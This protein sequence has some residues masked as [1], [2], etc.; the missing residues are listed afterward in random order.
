M[1]NLGGFRPVSIPVTGLMNNRSM[2]DELKPNQFRLLKNVSSVS[3]GTICRMPGWRA[4][5]E[6]DDSGN[7]VVGDNSDLHDQM[8]ELVVEDTEYTDGYTTYCDAPTFSRPYCATSFQTNKGREAVTL[9]HEFVSGS[10]VR[11][12]I[13]GTQSRVYALS[14]KSNSWRIIADGLGGTPSCGCSNRR[15]HIAQMGSTVV[16][17]NNHDQVLYWKFDQTETGCDYQSAIPIP[18]LQ[19]LEIDK[20]SVVVEYKGFIFLINVEASGTRYVSK[21]V[22]SDIGAPLSW[23]PASGSL[24]GDSDIG[25]PS[26][27]VIEAKVLGDYLWIFKERSI[28]RCTLVDPDEGLFNFQQ[29]YKG[30]NTPRYRNSIVSTGNAIFFMGH[31]DIY[32]IDLFSQEPRS[33]E[34]MTDATGMIFDQTCVFSS[35]NLVGGIDQSACDMSVAGYDSVRQQLW[36]SWVTSVNSDGSSNAE[37][38]QGSFSPRHTASCPNRSIMFNMRDRTMSYVDHG[39]TAFINYRPDERPSLRD[40]LVEYAG[41]SEDCMDPHRKEGDTYF[42]PPLEPAAAVSYILNETE[43]PSLPIDPDSLCARLGNLGIEDLCGNCPS[44]TSFLMASA[45]DYCIKEYTEDV[46]HREHYTVSS[47]LYSFIGYT[48]VIET[49]AVNF[50][51]DSEKYLSRVMVEARAPVQSGTQLLGMRLGQSSQP[52]CEVWKTLTSQPLECQ[53]L[54]TD[55]TT[56]RPYDKLYFNYYMRGRYLFVRF[57]VSGTTGD[58][59]F[60]KMDVYIRR[61]E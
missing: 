16:L 1:P 17:S 32:Y 26:E 10:G 4:Y 7:P 30:E 11:K 29:V 61:A 51:T 56:F 59:R 25:D 55:E 44:S 6:H 58:T 50:G 27:A 41:L 5:M 47:G 52:E 12:L 15:F 21:A 8:V 45:A 38:T 3:S 37:T 53:T 57:T 28:W 54:A 48:T 49:G 31:D 9:L 43:D 24:A 14:D 60:S 35:E 19:E 36:F 40:F 20:S 13:A 42:F 18:E 2:A 46:Y 39:F 34:W 22:W 23:V 33:V